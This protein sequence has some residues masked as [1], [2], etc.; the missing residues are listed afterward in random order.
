MACPTPE[1]TPTPAGWQVLDHFDVV[2]TTE[3]FDESLLAIARAAGLRALGYARLA[4]NNKPRHPALAKAALRAMLLDLGVTSLTLPVNVTAASHG[5]FVSNG[6]AASVGV[7]GGVG[8]NGGG[9]GGRSGGGLGGGSGGADVSARAWSGDAIRAMS[10]LNDE[11][12]QYVL[13]TRRDKA[14]QLLKADCNFY[15][16]TVPLEK[17]SG[18][19]SAELCAGV[20]GEELISRMLE[21]T[22]TDRGMHAEAT[23]R[24]DAALTKLAAE[25]GKAA[26]RA[27]SLA[28]QVRSDETPRPAGATLTPASAHAPPRASPGMGGRA[29]PTPRPRR[30]APTP[31]PARAHAHARPCPPAPTPTRARGRAQLRSI[32]EAS[33]DVERRRVLAIGENKQKL[34]GVRLCGDPLRSCIGCEPNVVPGTE[35]CWPPWDA[36]AP[37]PMHMHMPLARCT[38]TCPTPDA[39]AHAHE[40]CTCTCTGME[41]CWPSWEDQF[42]P[43]EQKVR[44]MCMCMWMGMCMCMR[45]RA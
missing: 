40:T 22:A 9:S 27:P 30:A 45:T 44:R 11:S 17:A 24:L 26:G 29:A 36:H 8:G 20:R 7:G 5:R 18:I 38:C 34:C 4:A 2:G 21:A 32:G 43:D 39:H 41:P 35:P 31:T 3:R 16:C 25:D 10:A 13:R 15:P 37:R 6:G 19:V 33:A 42:S 12:M 28:A 23:R 1:P 14:G